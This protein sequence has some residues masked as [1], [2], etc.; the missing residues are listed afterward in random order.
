MFSKETTGFSTQIFNFLGTRQLFKRNKQFI[1][2]YN[3]YIYIYREIERDR[4]RER[5]IYGDIDIYDYKV[6]NRTL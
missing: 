5:E 4:E 1:N 6:S 3:I 2:N